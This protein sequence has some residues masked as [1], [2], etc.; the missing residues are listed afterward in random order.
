MK[1]K[2]IRRFMLFNNIKQRK[3][4]LDNKLRKNMGTNKGILHK[5]LSQKYS[6]SGKSVVG[7]SFTH[8]SVE[9]KFVFG[10][11]K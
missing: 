10:H 2:E 5:N 7:W 11:K 3:R 6:E 8:F 1:I 4:K 9:Y